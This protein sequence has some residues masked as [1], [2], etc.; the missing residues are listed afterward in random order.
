VFSPRAKLLPD[1]R[2]DPAGFEPASTTWTECRAAIAPR[3]LWE[4]SVLVGLDSK[5]SEAN[6]C[7]LFQIGNRW[8]FSF[9]TLQ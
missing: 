2:M 6:F 7:P 8:K 5:G 4:V 3:A 1:R 9:R